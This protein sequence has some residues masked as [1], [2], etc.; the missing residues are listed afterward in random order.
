MY[1]LVSQLHPFIE[2]VKGALLVQHPTTRKT[3]PDIGVLPPL[4]YRDDREA[5][6]FVDSE[7]GPRCAWPRDGGA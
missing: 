3:P 1:S 4:P 2:A 6:R 7:S 5:G